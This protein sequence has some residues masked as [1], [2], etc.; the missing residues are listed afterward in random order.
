MHPDRSAFPAITKFVLR[1]HNP[2]NCFGVLKKQLTI[3]RSDIMFGSMIYIYIYMDRYV[4][5][6]SVVPK[7]CA[8]AISTKINK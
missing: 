4:Y 2:T 3:N 1:Y 7:L 5:S 8:I 6:S